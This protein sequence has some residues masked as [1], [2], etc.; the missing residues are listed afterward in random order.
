MK[1]ILLILAGYSIC[2][3]AFCTNTTGCS[4]Y[5][6]PESYLNQKNP[7]YLELNNYLHHHE[8]LPAHL[9]YIPQ[10]RIIASS[11]FNESQFV[12]V[13]AGKGD[14]IDID[15]RG[16]FHGFNQGQPF[17]Y[18]ALPNNNMNNNKNYSQIVAQEQ[19]ILNTLPQYQQL[20][21]YEK[22]LKAIP[23]SIT[24]QICMSTAISSE[25]QLISKYHQTYFRI[26]ITDHL[27]PNPDEIQQL[28]AIYNNLLKNN[29]QQWVYLHCL[30]GDGRT[31]T[32]ILMLTI[33]KQQTG[34]TLQPLPELITMVEQQSNYQL[35]PNCLKSDLT[36]RCQGK[37][38][39]YHTIEKF[40]NWVKSQQNT[41]FS[42][43]I[44]KNN[45]H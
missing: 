25:A 22:N 2:Q 34:G 4:S 10:Y 40:Y 38:Q 30:G 27:A 1:K 41:T 29:P 37:W 36:Y 21:F 13:I 16:E 28:V 19:Q 18:I 44:S 39:R 35:I 43:Y 3:P 9:R 42:N 8:A 20:A 32:A 24:R 31:T 11:Q 7:G 26:P 17:S 6:L 45:Y 14:I 33:L 23:E 15:L 12:N 5:Q